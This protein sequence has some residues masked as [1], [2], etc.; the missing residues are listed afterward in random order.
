MPLSGSASCGQW[1]CSS[2]LLQSVMGVLL[3]SVRPSEILTKSPGGAGLKRRVSSSKMMETLSVSSDEVRLAQSF[4]QF[5]VSAKS[6]GI[7]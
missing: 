2:K 3:G 4:D 7:S 5:Q 1:L 6:R